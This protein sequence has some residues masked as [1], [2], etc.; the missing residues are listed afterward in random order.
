MYLAQT[1]LGPG[2]TVVYKRVKF[3]FH[4]DQIWRTFSV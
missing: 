1:I 4:K 2:D 3:L